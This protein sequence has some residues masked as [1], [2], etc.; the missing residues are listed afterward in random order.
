MR[1]GKGGGRLR[2]SGGGTPKEMGD[3]T[4]NPGGIDTGSGF[5]FW[6]WY[7]L[8]RKDES[9]QVIV[10]SKEKEEVVRVFIGENNYRGCT[11]VRSRGFLNKTSL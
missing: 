7:G 4:T 9:A 2:S 5:D 3:E 10:Y 8:K 1:G 11:C 6:G